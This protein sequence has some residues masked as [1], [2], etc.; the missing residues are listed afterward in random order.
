MQNQHM[1]K[2]TQYGHSFQT[3]ALAALIT[4]RDFLQQSADIISPNYF[5]GVLIL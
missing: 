4:D 1:N 2:L 5:E 3:K